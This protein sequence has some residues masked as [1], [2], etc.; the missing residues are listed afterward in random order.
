MNN[1][2]NKSYYSLNYWYESLGST[3]IHEIVY[4][5][6]VPIGIIGIL[7]NIL[8]LFILRSNKF[9]LSFYTYLRAYTICSVFICFFNA[10]QF[11]AGV[12]RSLPFTNSK[13]SIQYFSYV[14]IP[15]FTGI[16]V[17]GTSLDVVLSIERVALLSNRMHWFR[18]V[19]PKKLCFILMIIFSILAIPYWFFFEP[20]EMEV[21]LNETTTIRLHY[22]ITH[23]STSFLKFYFYVYSCFVDAIP[24]VVETSLNIIS[25]IMIKKYVKQKLRILVGSSRS[26]SRS[27]Q[28]ELGNLLITLRRANESNNFAFRSKQMEIK[29]TI[30]VIFL[31]IVSIM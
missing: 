3:L 8:A 10:T 18:S 12:R 24:I 28:I 22:F 7:L 14:Y 6:L 16:N 5:S 25:V 21:K 2:A 20:M 26:S 17:Y 4:I 23:H 19:N 30:L 1:T 13:L 31:S 15:F 11:S 29:L 9:R 27:N